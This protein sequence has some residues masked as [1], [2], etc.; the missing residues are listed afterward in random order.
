MR[1]EIWYGYVRSRKLT[2]FDVLKCNLSFTLS[3]M[4]I[5][6]SIFTIGICFVSYFSKI[7]LTTL[8]SSLY[9]LEVWKSKINSELPV[10]QITVWWLN[11]FHSTGCEK[12]WSNSGYIL[13]HSLND[14]PLDKISSV[15][16]I[17]DVSMTISDF[18]I[19]LSHTTFQGNIWGIWSLIIPDW[20]CNPDEETYLRM[21]NWPQK[22]I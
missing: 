16:E 8:E 20:V 13:K 3:M 14:L 18:M 4:R 7:T 17:Q 2:A 12:N 21:R 9:W 11:Q 15:I 1:S 19:S 22:P 5:H 6:S 10:I